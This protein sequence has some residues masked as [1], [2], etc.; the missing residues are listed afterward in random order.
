MLCEK[1]KNKMYWRIQGSTQGWI[2]P[3]CGWGIVTTYI[4]E[5]DADE[6]EYSLYIRNVVGID[7]EKI[8]F[9]AKAANVNYVIAKHMLEE[10]QT[11]I[12]KAKA[13]KI[14]ATITKLQELKMDF[15]V[16]PYFK[17]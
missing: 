8:S 17:Y 12:L 3:A 11:C 2:C 13:S 15:N 14:K 5:I 16:I 7:K 1:C 10:E 9:V 4:D 6:T